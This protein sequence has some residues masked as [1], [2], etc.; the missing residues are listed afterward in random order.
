ML[1]RRDF[2]KTAGLWTAA[3]L[4]QARQP[5]L[6]L[7]AAGT[8][9]APALDPGLRTPHLEQLAREG[10]RFDRMYL[11]CP[12][13][14]PS[15]ASLITGRFPFA[16]G[17]PRDGV[18]LPL[19]QPSIAE[20]FQGAGYRTG[21]LGEWRL[22]GPETAA[23]PA[24]RRH[25]FEFWSAN[26]ADAEPFVKQN[27]QKPFFALVAWPA[28]QE[29]PH[30][31]VHDPA[32]IQL[33]A[34]VPENVAV[35]ARAD[36]AAYFDA[37]SAIDGQAGRLLAALDEQRLSNDTIVVFTA[38]HG[39]MLGS[40]GLEGGDVPFEEA[41]RAPLVIRYPGRLEPGRR[42]DALASNVDLLPALLALCSVRP[43]ED[44]Q[45]RDLMSAPQESAYSVGRLGAPGEWRMVVRGFDKLV[46]DRE[47]NVTHL[48]NLA[49]DPLELDN[50]AQEPSLDLKRD[51]LKALL[52]DWM[53][54]TGDGMDPSGL[55][56]R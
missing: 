5:N 2:L 4:A 35:Q 47:Q 32:R 48:Y 19:D 3:G 24:P 54:R 14:G 12:A 9:R 27:R 21:F 31:A 51:E 36:S 30:A 20:L 33:R 53:R 38:L 43:A 6:L 1:G 29:T 49:Q 50:R 34:N 22:D 52:K 15:Q 42:R 41:V 16:C 13:S 28:S 25:G 26:A 10:V 39:S 55:K 8:W 17:V 37:C 7:L 44:V 18:R 40:Q 11:S 45:G 56:K 46:V 23:P